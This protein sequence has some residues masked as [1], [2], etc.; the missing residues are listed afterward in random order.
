MGKMFLD[1]KQPLFT[2]KSTDCSDC[3]VGK[4]LNCHFNIRQLL[5]FLSFVFPVMIF[6]GY[7]IIYYNPVFIIPWIIMFIS[8][9][10]FIEIR[11]MCSHCPHYG[12]PGIKSLK[13]WANYGSPKLWKYRAGPMS[14]KERIIFFA[15]IFTIF[16]YPV[17]FFVL[18][19]EIQ[20]IIQLVVYLFLF[21]LA[22]FLLK[23]YYCSYCINFAC[24]LNNVDNKIREV[25]FSKNP[26][27]GDAWK[28]RGK[29]D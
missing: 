27:V 13:C 18:V 15:G 28:N 1:S 22:S 9:F 11:V 16:A 26:V 8:F 23:K 29:S 17:L 21:F 25:F 10:G 24:P 12:E 7:R 4:S 6:G 14:I 3:E 2:C 5:R 19:P 20:H